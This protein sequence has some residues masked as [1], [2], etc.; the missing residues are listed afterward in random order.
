MT[1]QNVTD[2]PRE[3]MTKKCPTCAG[4]G[5]VLSEQSA[6][7]E[8]ER[9]LRALAFESAAK[10]F[11]VAVAA[12][13]G[14]LVIGAGASR[15]AEIEAQTK[16]RFFLELVDDVH[17]DH[18]AVVAEGKLADLTPESPVEEGAELELKLVELARHDVAAA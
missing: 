18:F 2:G 13:P 12:K 10:A 3:V 16:R 11:R 8:L 9:R 4:D 17:L 15:L 6:A 1:R 14:A 7:V 5:I